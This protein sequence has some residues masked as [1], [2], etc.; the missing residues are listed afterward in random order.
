MSSRDDWLVPYDDL[1]V[2]RFHRCTGC[3]RGPLVHAGI[4]QVGA[5]ALATHVCR[6]F[7][8]ILG[9]LLRITL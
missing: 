3:G 7:P 8:R 1:M 9:K 5:L 6:I 2:E 4:L